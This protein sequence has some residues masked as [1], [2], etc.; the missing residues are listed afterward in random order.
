MA[1]QLQM[2][3]PSD[4]DAVVE[5][6]VTGFKVTPDAPFVNRRLLQWKYFEPGPRWEGTRSYLLRDGDAVRAHCGVLPINLG[7]AGGTVTCLCFTDWVGSQGFPGAGVLLKQKMMGFA[8][9]AIVVGGTA[10]T[11]AVIP[12]LNYKVAGNVGIFARVVRLWNQFRTRPKEGIVKEAARLARNAMLSRAPAMAIPEGWSAVRLQSF[13][14]VFAPVLNR[15]SSAHPT[16]ERSADY[17]NYWLR[18]PAA[19]IA[20][21]AILEGGRIRGYF[22]L[23]RIEG[24]ARI[25]DV[26]LARG[27]GTDLEEQADWNAAYALA[28]KTAENDPETCEISAVASTKFAQAALLSSGFRQRGGLPLALYDPQGKLSAA[29]AIFWN[30]IDGD[31]AYLYD[32]ALPYIT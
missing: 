21:F 32:P 26:R 25:I 1:L 15:L 2:T 20:G 16:P 30:M 10:D 29:P 6:L 13:D 8:E 17:L 18:C 28:A 4:L 5:A 14:S 24:Q 31:I 27:E 11:R 12:R 9:T 19:G 7:F 23:T 22:L 3:T